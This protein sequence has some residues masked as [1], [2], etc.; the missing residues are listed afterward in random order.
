ML[1]IAK[2]LEPLWDDYLV[3]TRYTDARL[4]VNKPQRIGSV[5][6]FDKPWEGKATC[7]FHIIK[8]DDIYRMYYLGWNVGCRNLP[9]E[10][11]YVCYAESKDG[12][13]WVRPSLGIQEYQGSTDNNILIDPKKLTDGFFVMKDENPNCPPNMKYKA[14]TQRLHENGMPYLMGY[15]SADGIH[16]EE[17]GMI[18]D[19]YHYDSLN[20]LIWSQ[21]K[22]KYYLFFRCRHEKPE[23]ANSPFKETKVRDLIVAESEDFVN[24]SEP[25]PFDFQ[26][27]EDYPLYTNAISEYLYDK[28]Y[29]VGFPTRYNERREW[30]ASFER[31]CGKENRKYLMEY[32]AKHDFEKTPRYGLAI[33]DGLFMFSRDGYTWHRFDEACYPPGPER[34][35][36]WIYG[37]GY[38][39]VG[40]I[41]TPGRY[42]DEEPEITQF[43]KEACW[44]RKTPELLR[45]VWRKDGFA[46]YKA[47][48]KKTM[49]LTKP[50][51]FEGETLSMNFCTSARGGIYIK[52]LDEYSNPIEG[53]STCEM[54]GDSVNRIIDF[55]KPFGELQGKKIRLQFEMRDAELFALGFS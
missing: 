5:M 45:Y 46:S 23:D 10:G 6:T 55:D 14:V 20:V 27:A 2:G 19:G 15:V 28:R 51:T 22:G 3:D 35:M 18:S 33:T 13:E 30:N 25:K 12:L 47:D 16:F 29:F 34:D 49:L 31:L 21:A 11:F 42:E 24:W 38:P 8:D 9:H 40:L 43:V 1:H 26:G 39:A 37:N 44:D 54:F 50:F 7:Y 36:S 41:E 32:S 53:Y 52:V 48:Y 4:S 17:Y